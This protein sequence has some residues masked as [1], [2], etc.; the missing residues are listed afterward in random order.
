[1]RYITSLF[2]FIFVFNHSAFGQQADSFYEV[3][4]I[5]DISIEFEQEK[6]NY[7]L[8]SL[9]YNGDEVLV[10]TVTINDE[11]FRNVGIRWAATRA[12][13]IGSKRNSLEVFLNHKNKKQNYQG[14][15]SLKLLIALRDPSLV[16]EVLSY[17][18]Y[19]RYM[20]SPRANYARINVNEE[21]IGLFVNVEMVDESFLTR[22]FGKK[23]GVLYKSTP[24]WFES[25]PSGCERNFYASL[26]YE[27]DAAC[28]DHHFDVIF[29]EEF[30]DLAELSRV[31]NQ[32]PEDIENILDVDETLWMLALNNCLTNLY[33]YS[34]RYSQ[35]YYL[36][37][38]AEGIFHP[39]PGEMNLSIGSFKNIGVGSDL[40]LK[41]I[42]ELDPFLHEENAE[43]P[44]ISQ[45]LK[46]DY[47]KKLYLSHLRMIYLTYLQND[48]YLLRA[49]EMHTLIQDDFMEDPYKNYSPE[50]FNRSLSTTIGQR[51]RIPGIEE[52]LG[53]RTS[54]LRRNSDLQ[55][56]PPDIS[57]VD[58]EKRERFESQ[59]LKEFRIHAKV[60][61]FPEQVKLYY[62][63]EK[64]APF[65]STMMMNDGKHYD[66]EADDEVFGVVIT[67]EK[68]ASEIEYY[69][70]AENLK[71]VGFSP[72]D[73]INE[74]HST[75]L[76]EINR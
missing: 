21:Y 3:G 38:D 75:S 59:R 57:E 26:Q 33:S 69:I 28:Y 56:L 60:G 34:G 19:G 41:Q 66:G 15:E 40:T 1:M 36:Y 35:N 63:F 7:L 50:E 52:L 4:T 20:P 76:T 32:S 72:A 70:V 29:G 5:Q 27:Q 58:V 9:R 12:L 45:L 71:A 39:I 10:G 51:S 17:E 30:D 43:F 47:Y 42:Q 55:I 67:P 73:Y 44:L 25:G 22:N 6:W 14:I 2:F 64:D 61:R 68:G 31:L 16:R 48:N 53:G 49:K 18:I 11:V 13:Q 8:D 54:F 24:N 62:R 65:Q 23:T 37:K 46:N 74:R